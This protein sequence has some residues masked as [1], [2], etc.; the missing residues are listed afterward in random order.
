M[1]VNRNDMTL[2]RIWVFFFCLS[3]CDILLLPLINVWYRYVLLHSYLLQKIKRRNHHS[4]DIQQTYSGAYI[5]TK[6][7][8]GSPGPI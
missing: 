5:C 4:R 8:F 6:W 1:I 3:L 7:K 2:S